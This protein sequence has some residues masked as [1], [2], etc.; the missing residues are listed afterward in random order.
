MGAEGFPGGRSGKAPA[1]AGLRRVRTPRQLVAG[2]LHGLA[3]FLRLRLIV[4]RG[5]QQRPA[6]R[7]R[8][9]SQVSQKALCRDEFRLRSFLNQSM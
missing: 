1:T 5:A 3:L 8:H 7:V 6:H 4:P 2:L 9:V